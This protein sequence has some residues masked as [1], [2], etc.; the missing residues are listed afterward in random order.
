MK[1]EPKMARLMEKA[2]FTLQRNNRIPPPPAVCEEWWRQAEDLIKRKHKARPKFGLGYINLEGSDEEEE[3]SRVTCHATFVSSGDDTE[4]SHRGLHRQS[5]RNGEPSEVEEELGSTSAPPELEDGGQPTVDELV[6]VNLG[7][8]DDPRP[9]FVSAT[10]TEEEREGYRSFLM[11]YR[12]CFAWNYKEMP[13]LDP[14]VATHKLA[15]D[16]HHRPVKQPPRRLRPEFE[17]QVIAEVDKLILAGFI[18][19]AKY[20]RWLANIVTGAMV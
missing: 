3:G 10:L 19:E 8:E 7:T 9:T 13:G 17:D 4:T 6:E 14:R 18:K 2:G 5:Y 12:D 11:E 20:T 15:I 1:A 16:P